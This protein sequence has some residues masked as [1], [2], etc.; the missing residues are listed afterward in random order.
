MKKWGWI[1]VVL[2]VVAALAVPVVNLVKSGPRHTA[3]ATCADPKGV[4]VVTI[5]EPKCANCHAAGT[6]MPFYAGWPVARPLVTRDVARGLRWADLG[7][8]LNRKDPPTVSDGTLAKLERVVSNG[9]MP[10]SRFTALHWNAGLTDS[11]RG[12]VLAWV[13]EARKAAAPAGVAETVA[14]L[15]IPPIPQHAEADA[16]K[17]ALGSKLYN[18]NRLSGDDTLSCADCHDLAKGGTDQRPVSVGIRGQKGGINAPTTFNARWQ[19]RNFWDGRAKDLKE[20]AG[21]PPLNPIEMGSTWEG[22]VAKLDGDKAFAAEFKAVYPQGFSADTITDAIAEYEKTLTTPDSRFDHFLAGEKDALSPQEVHGWARFQELGCATCHS[23]VLLGGT[24]FEPMGREGDYFAD[25]GNPTGADLGRLNF[26]KDPADKHHFK[27]PTLRN[28]A[29]TYPYFHDATAPD[30]A[31]AE[32][33]MAK[34]Q[35][36]VSL[37]EDDVKDMEAFLRSLTGQFQGKQL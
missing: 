7:R 25:R 12:A 34:Y 19:F 2:A 16:A 22:I 17:A 3:M 26:S 28:V 35:L 6:P 36:G 10:P 9:S 8:E 37:S 11:E 14:V 21:G 33:A 15:V 5:L 23:G 32:K 1:V 20:Q 30:L 31:T 4:A 27:V 29:L 24:S 13:R 18:D